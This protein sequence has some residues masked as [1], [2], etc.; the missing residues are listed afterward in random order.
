MEVSGAI[1]FHVTQAYGMP[2]V[3][4]LVHA[5]R[6]G[7]AAG[8]ASI[9]RILPAAPPIGAERSMALSRI[10]AATVNRPMEFDGATT[11]S[12]HATLQL[13]TRAADKV[14]AAVSVNLGRAI[15]LSA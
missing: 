1:P 14:E 11:V 6:A 15:D 8:T 10:V 4:P 9:S 2:G 13:Y 5:M 12:P 7:E 3:A